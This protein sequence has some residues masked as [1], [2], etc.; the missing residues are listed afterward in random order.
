MKGNKGAA[1]REAG[2]LFLNPRAVIYGLVLSF[3]WTGIIALLLGFFGFY[4][5]GLGEKTG[6]LVSLAGLGGACLGA[7]A[8]ARRGKS[9]GWLHGGLVG[10]AFIILSYLIGLAWQRGTGPA[11]GL[12]LSR[13]LWGTALGLLGGMLG[14]NI[15]VQ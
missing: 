8:A 10:F 3:L 6:T 11:T 12:F 14:V 2:R 13:L 5:Q 7:A 1:G 4:V 15:G 9:L